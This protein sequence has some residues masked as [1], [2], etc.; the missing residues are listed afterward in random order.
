MGQQQLLLIVA[1]VIVVALMVSVGIMLFNDNA[2][3]SNRDALANDLVNLASRAQ[4]YERRPPLLA[5]GN[6]SFVGFTLGSYTKNENGTF[7][8]ANVSASG[9]DIQATG[10]ETGYDNVT[11]VKVVIRVTIDSVHVVEMN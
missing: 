5:G 10:V 8:V 3:A 7:Q 9:L 2:S 6:G 4:E 11:P 1:G